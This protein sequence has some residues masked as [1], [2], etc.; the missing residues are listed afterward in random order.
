MTI[1]MTTTQI[2]KVKD[3][4][5]ITL[6][7]ESILVTEETVLKFRLFN[8]KQLSSLEEIKKFDLL[9]TYKNKAI[10]YHLKYGKNSK[11]VLNYLLDKE[12]DYDEAIIIVDDLI[13]KK[14]IN[15]QIICDNLASSLARN[16][17]GPLMIKM[18]LYNRFFS[19]NNINNALEQ[20]SEEDYVDGY[21]KLLEKAKNKYSNIDDSYIRKHKIKEYMYRHGYSNVEISDI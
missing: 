1:N 12:L 14:I 4:Y 19:Q 10:S 16:S 18:K 15:D 8:E 3:K 6:G 7:E 5:K 21:E 17:N 2:K 13:A 11:E 9:E 20:I